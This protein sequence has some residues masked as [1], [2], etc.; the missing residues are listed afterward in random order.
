MDHHSHHTPPASTTTEYIKFGAIVAVILIASYALYSQ[1][2]TQTFQ[3]YLRWF[4]GVFMLTFAGFKLAGY[5]MFVMMFP[6]Y[7]LIAQKSKTY[8]Y[9]YPFIQLGL[10][11]LFLAGAIGIIRE[12]LTLLIG[13]VAAA[14][15][16]K[17]VF[18]KKQTI[19]CACLGNI[20]KLPLSTVSFFEDFVM[21]VMAAIMLALRLI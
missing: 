17:Q 15:V 3:E 7:D 4:M 8:T 2:A 11:I 20:I 5:K 1:S 12:A 21:A 13:T 9:A 6:G 14:G 10:A 19:Q 18:V 16:Y